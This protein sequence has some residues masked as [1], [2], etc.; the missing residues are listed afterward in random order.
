M[1]QSDSCNQSLNEKPEARPARGER[2]KE[3]LQGSLTAQ[4][5]VI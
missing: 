3:S 2:S 4:A 5:K 1:K